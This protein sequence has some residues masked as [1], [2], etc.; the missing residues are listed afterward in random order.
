MPVVN[1]IGQAFLT[2][3]ANALNLV[4]TFIPK[5]LGFLVILLIG[6]LIAS[7][8][9]RTVVFVL[10]RIGFER[11]GARIGLARLEQNTGMRFDVVAI[12]GTI[13]YWFIFL[14]FLVPAVDA[15]GL[16]TVSNILNELIA[17]I[18]N[19]FVAVLVLF[20]GLL[21]ASV[22][23][24]IV[25]G[26]MATTRV[27]NPALFASIARYALI[28][29]AGLIALEQLQIAPSLLNILFT[30][31]VG[32]TA[33]A[34]GLAF[35]LGGQDAARRLLNRSSM[36]AVPASESGQPL[37]AGESSRTTQ[38]TQPAAPATQPRPEASR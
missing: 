20:L 14:I 11:L 18:P 29:F 35:G 22:V 28:G 27:G 34:F 36:L 10:R 9:R 26:L 4:L 16:S 37:P 30:A 31:V 1:N 25:R 7:V 15:L 24:D 23:G 19:V 13:V 12:L 8:L 6:W 32:G 3:L 17:Y 2:S 38:P 21:A 33:L 5:F